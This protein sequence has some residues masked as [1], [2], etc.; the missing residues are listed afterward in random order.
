MSTNTTSTRR[1]IERVE[2]TVMAVNSYV[3]DGPEG[4]VV[5]DGQL[6]VTDARSVRTVIDRF[7]RP[8]AGLI[9]THA[10][11]DHYAGAST[12]LD[13]LSAPII[14]TAGVAEVIR[15]DDAEKD[16]IVGPMMGVEWPS[17]RRFVDEIA[18][19]GSSVRLGGL[20]F[21]VRELG[22][23]ESGADTLWVLDDTTV[24]SGDIAYNDM[25]AYLLDG[26]FDE[27]LD[28][29]ADL[30]RSLDAASVLYVGHGEPTDTTVLDRQAA[31]IRAFVDV[32]SAHLDDTETR[33]HDAVVA[34]MSPLASDDRLLF[35][36][37]LSI[38]PA[39]AALRA[40]A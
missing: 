9:V 28:V 14:A 16:G 13:G 21:S 12:I 24:F 1:P 17:E 25:H 11:P 40:R 7:D 10:H 31:Y 19:P 4:L 38:E 15:R 2:G 30:D 18:V 32:V 39:A 36:M 5:I 23:A 34:A 35:L 26:F 3:V 27:W 37:E 6:T 8:V 22:A 20:E 29:L 33:R